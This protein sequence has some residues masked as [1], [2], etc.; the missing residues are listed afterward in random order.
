ML[1]LLLAESYSFSSS[2]FIYLPIME[3]E[4]KIKPLLK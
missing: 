2:I 1:G 4:F 3:K